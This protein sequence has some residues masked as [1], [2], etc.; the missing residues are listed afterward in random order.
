MST[1]AASGRAI[2]RVVKVGGSLFDWV[3]LP[4]ALARWLD[5][6]PPAV[7]V[8]VAGGGMLANAVRQVDRMHGLGEEPSHW[9]CVELLGVTARMLCVILGER[10]R[11]I[12]KLAE[13]RNV[14]ESQSDLWLVFDARD[15]LR[16]H[17]PQLPGCRLPATWSVTSDSIA[18][19]VAQAIDADELVL[20]KSASAPRGMSL[21]ELSA[22]GYV[23]EF[24]PTIAAQWQGRIRLVNLRDQSAAS[25]EQGAGPLR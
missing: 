4:Q 10:A 22:C 19:R 12:C 2:L 25:S 6:Q 23:D 14:Y 7:N 1:Y 24:L 17:E 20:L 21:T 16:D 8:L 13:I 3:Q 15:F 11:P 18:A 5:E 9:L